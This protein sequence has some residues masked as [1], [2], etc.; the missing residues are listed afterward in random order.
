MRHY[1]DFYN[2]LNDASILVQPILNLKNS[3]SLI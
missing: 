2:L 3:S 1:D